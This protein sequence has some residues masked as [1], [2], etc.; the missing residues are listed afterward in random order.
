VTV[1]RLSR[2][3]RKKGRDGKRSI[4]GFV[5]MVNDGSGRQKS[6]RDGVK[7]VTDG[8]RRGWTAQKRS[9]WTVWRARDLSSAGSAQRTAGH[10]ARATRM[11]RWACNRSRAGLGTDNSWW[12]SANDDNQ[13]K[14]VR[15][16]E[17]W[18]GTGNSLARSAS[19]E[20]QPEGA[21]SV[22]ARKHSRRLLGNY[23]HVEATGLGTVGSYS[24]VGT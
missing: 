15:S 10:E 8:Q 14:G 17:S 3:I 9:T 24:K 18:L 19:D 12:R 13:P 11:N 22:D 23:P 1:E 5:K 7:T 2:T 20:K 4:R 16:V 6:V 21:Q